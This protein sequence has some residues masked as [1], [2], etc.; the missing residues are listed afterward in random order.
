MTL[1]AVCNTYIFPDLTIIPVK[2][3]AAGCFCI[4]PCCAV[5]SCTGTAFWSC[6]QAISCLLVCDL[7]CSWAEFCARAIGASEITKATVA[8]QTFRFMV[9]TSLPQVFPRPTKGCDFFLCTAVATRLSL[10]FL[11]HPRLGTVTRSPTA[12]NSFR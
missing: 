11:V 10:T 2:D 9:A 12:N 1:S 5:V 6:V 7:V 8:S 4:S 3:W